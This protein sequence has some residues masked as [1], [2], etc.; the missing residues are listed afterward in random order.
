MLTCFNT[1]KLK[2]FNKLKHINTGCILKYILIST[3][4]I[5]FLEN[6]DTLHYVGSLNCKSSTTANQHHMQLTQY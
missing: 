3:I 2:L 5:K 4:R 1:T 6:L